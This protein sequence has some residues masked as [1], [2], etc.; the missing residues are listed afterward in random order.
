MLNEQFERLEVAKWIVRFVST[1]CI[2]ILEYPV[3]I[4]AAMME[5]LTWIKRHTYGR[6]ERLVF[7]LFSVFIQFLLC[8]CWTSSCGRSE[9][10]RFELHR[11]R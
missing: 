8:E 1:N 5:I 6:L 2:V 11:C 4:L 7:G 9:I 10:F 3:G